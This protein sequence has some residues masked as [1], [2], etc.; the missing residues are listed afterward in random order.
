VS[1]NQIVQK[2]AILSAIFFLF[3]PGQA[4]AID[5]TLEWDASPGA[6]YYVLH[7]GPSP[8]DY[9]TGSVNVG[10][11]DTWNLA[12]PDVDNYIAVKAWTND[13][14]QSNYSREICVL[15][16]ASIGPGYD[17]GWAI[18]TGNLKGFSVMYHSSDP[19]PTLGPSEGIPPIP[20]HNG[21]GSP[22]NLEVQPPDWTFNVPPKIFIPCPGYQN[23]SGLDV[24]YYDDVTMDWYLAN[25]ADQPDIVQ[26]EAEQWM[27]QGSRDN[28]ESYA[29]GLKVK[30]FSGTQAVAPPRSGDSSSG[31]GCFVASAAAD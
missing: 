25:D 31:G 7:W 10:N 23:V 6:D 15:G 30:H 14:I 1:F 24:Y 17:R 4:F 20:A 13:G 12:L 5:V 8:G 9:S 2:A 29:V 21:L 3:F 22:L 11:T 19:T 16:P 28:S 26:P 18:T 27:V